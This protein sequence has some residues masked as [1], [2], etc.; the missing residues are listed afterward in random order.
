MPRRLRP[1]GIVAVRGSAVLP[2]VCVLSVACSPLAEPRSPVGLGQ[3][4][5]VPL[6]LQGLLQAALREVFEG[7]F[8]L[9][10]GRS[11]AALWQKKKHA[12]AC[13][14]TPQAGTERGFTRAAASRVCRSLSRSPV[15]APSLEGTSMH[16][17][18]CASGQGLGPNPPRP[19]GGRVEG[20]P[21][22]AWPLGWAGKAARSVSPVRS[23]DTAGP[24]LRV[25]SRGRLLKPVTP[26]LS[27]PLPP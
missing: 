18:P 11:K 20:P 1:F 12:T 16:A 3:T 14:R 5:S 26:A 8:E 21:S 4:N 22:S 17:M 9:V 25:S 19:G 27:R 13:R 6:V 24:A 23:C 7:S 2:C 10:R 15:R